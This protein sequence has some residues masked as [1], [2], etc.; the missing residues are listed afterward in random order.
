SETL[1]SRVYPDSSELLIE[2]YIS[3]NNIREDWRDSPELASLDFKQDPSDLPS[4]T[5][6]VRDSV[7]TRFVNAI[8][9]NLLQVEKVDKQLSIIKVTVT[10]PDEVFSKSFNETLTQTV[11]SFYTETKT[12]KSTDNIA[13]L[14]QKVDS[15]RA[16]MENAIYSAAKVSDATP[17]IN[18]TRQIQRIGPVQ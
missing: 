10:S 4:T 8:N 17:N 3:Y 16:V 18:P 1:L 13:I 14:Q 2:R 12:R 7:I 6:R 5:L 15:V 9:E 11:N